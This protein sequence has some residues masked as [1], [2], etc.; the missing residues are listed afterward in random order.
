M[1]VL[2]ENQFVRFEKHSEAQRLEIYWVQSKDLTVED[3][4][5][6]LL[7]QNSLIKEYQLTSLLVD[8]RNM[9]F[10]I[11]PSLQ[12]WIQSEILSTMY[13]IKQYGFIVGEDVFTQVSVEQTMDSESSK[14]K[15]RYFSSLEEAREWTQLATSLDA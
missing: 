10:T 4:K 14:M 15:T 1:E 3:L 7:L 2:S 5:Q 8:T 6:I 11:A 13:S 12:D 9:A